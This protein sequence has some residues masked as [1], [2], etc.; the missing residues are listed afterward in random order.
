M[1]AFQ[2]VERLA[3]TGS[4]DAALWS[5]IIAARTRVARY[6]GDHVEVDKT[7]QVLFIV[8]GGKVTLTVATSTGATGNTPLG[9]WHVYRKVG[10]F[11]WVLYYPSYFLARLRRAR[12]PRRAAV[13][14]VARLRPH[15]DVDRADGLRAD[16][17]RLDGIRVP[18]S[19]ADD[20]VARFRER[21]TE[22]DRLILDAVNRRL[23][24]VAELKR[25]K[26]ANGI[27]FVDA[28]RER[29]MVDDPRR[30]ERRAAR[31]T[32]GCVR[33]TSSCSR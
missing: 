11:D 24:L 31:A 22:L 33:S 1:Y 16:R 27:A 15:P 7:R 3:R 20:E 6:G 21:I 9:T 12:V 30:R 10:G 32:T 17:L 29:S 19:N 8:R 23:E 4:V 5:R 14:R 25:Y 18:M 13:S 28:D 2:K 26:D